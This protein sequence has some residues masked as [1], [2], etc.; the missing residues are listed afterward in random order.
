MAVGWPWTDWLSSHVLY[1]RPGVRQFQTPYVQGNN[2]LIKCCAQPPVGWTTGL[3][4]RLLRKGGWKKQV[5]LG[6]PTEGI[7]R[8]PQGLW[9]EE[10]S[11]PQ[12]PRNFHGMWSTDCMVSVFA[13]GPALTTRLPACCGCIQGCIP[14]TSYLLKDFFFFNRMNIQLCN[15][16][17]NKNFGY[18]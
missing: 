1:Q 6:R 16:R 12:T 10:D 15:H 2:S 7:L 18:W 13:T 4:L 9:S 11:E 8:T 17:Q 5:K 14:H 3:G